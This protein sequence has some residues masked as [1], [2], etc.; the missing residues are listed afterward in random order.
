MKKFSQALHERGNIPLFP[1]PSYKSVTHGR[2]IAQIHLSRPSRHIAATNRHLTRSIQCL[3]WLAISVSL[4]VDNILKGTIGSQII[5]TSERQMFDKC[6]F[7]EEG[8][9]TKA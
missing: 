3:P 6:S 5:P 4:I 8:R 7:I 9:S 2:A 1:A